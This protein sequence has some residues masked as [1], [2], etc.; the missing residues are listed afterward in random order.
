[1]TFS[2]SAGSYVLD[3][4]F[5]HADGCV[6]DL[7]LL[8]KYIDKGRVHSDFKAVISILGLIKSADVQ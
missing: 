1:M 6:P 4:A 5:F 7:A 3:S 2:L 8:F